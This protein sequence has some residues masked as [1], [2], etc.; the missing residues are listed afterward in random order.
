MICSWGWFELYGKGWQGWYSMEKW[1]LK[2]LGE[3]KLLLGQQARLSGEDGAERS[4]SLDGE[5]IF[6]LD[7]R[8]L[9]VHITRSFSSEHFLSQKTSLTSLGD[10][11]ERGLPSFDLSL[12][13]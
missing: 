5:F 13:G 8:L 7:G 9:W 1:G 11:T 12:G 10:C 4:S 6:S 2:V 3:E